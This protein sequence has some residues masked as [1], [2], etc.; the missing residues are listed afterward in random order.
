MTA[1]IHGRLDRDFHLVEAD[2]ALEGLHLRAGG[3]A[4]GVIAVPQIATIA[5]LARRLGIVVSRG[6]IAADEDADL[7]LWV[8]AE[9]AGEGV[10]IAIAGWAERPAASAFPATTIDREHDFI[11]AAA[12]W[13]WE[14]DEALKLTA[15]SPGVVPSRESMLGQPLTKLVTLAENDSGILPIL[16]AIATQRRF[17]DQ[18][19]E[20]RDGGGLVR[21]SA[22]PIF[23][24][25]GR[26]A[27]FRGAAVGL[28]PATAPALAAGPG[29]G[30]VHDAAQADAF[31]RRLDAALRQPLDRIISGAEHIR[32]QVDGPLRRDYANYAADIAAAGRH[33]L[34]L[35]DDLVD[36]QAIE[37]PDFAPAIER[38]DLVDVTRR[39]AGLLGVK[40]ADANVRIDRPT[41]DEALPAQGDF[42]RALQ[43]L[44][45]IIGNAVRH[46]PAGGSV[47]LRCERQGQYAVVTVA[48]QGRGIDP[49]DHARI[50]EKFER[51]H[52]GDGAGTGVGLYIARRLARAMGGDL[53]V[54][55]ALGQGARFVFTLPAV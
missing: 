14:T 17:D 33:L 30:I 39:A 28:A 27:G 22:V 42:R 38:L 47:W 51:L 55:S 37:R 23:D 49:A 35:V 1:P 48:D 16:D 19:G 40:A 15:L 43:V 6:V 8:R 20:L 25:A 24:T 2:A 36:L 12:D 45:N 31:G 54:E 41:S 44:V 11:R 5:R 32:A 18:E 29:D 52:P 3:A 34:A 10:A 50:F 9:P 7:E 53:T 46:S 26:F 13:L 21:L 4:G